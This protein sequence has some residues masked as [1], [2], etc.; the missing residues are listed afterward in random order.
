MTFFNGPDG[1][2]SYA[3]TGPLSMHKGCDKILK[4]DNQTIYGSEN[5]GVFT[6]ARCFMD[7]IARQYRMRMPSH[8]IKPASCQDEYYAASIASRNW[9]MPQKEAVP[10][11]GNVTDIYK[12][13]CWGS[14][15]YDYVK[16]N[17]I[18][19]RNCSDF[20]KLLSESLTCDAENCTPDC[21]EV[22][23][24]ADSCRKG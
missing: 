14:F 19:F 13:D 15:N 24:F 6:D 22:D 21:T 18:E 3:F 23:D 17:L 11:S 20:P 9:F 8:Y 5:P 12:E 4:Q 7:W 1:D 2:G 16:K 10:G